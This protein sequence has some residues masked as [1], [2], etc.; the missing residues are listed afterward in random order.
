LIISA[1]LSLRQDQDRSLFH[2]RSRRRRGCARDRA[3]DR[4]PGEKPR[5]HDHPEGVETEQQLEQVRFLGCTEM[6]GYLFS[7]PRRVE[8]LRRLLRP[9]AVKRALIA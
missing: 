8:D 7:P 3:G 6:Q 1:Q 2:Q 9:R 5:H 4:R